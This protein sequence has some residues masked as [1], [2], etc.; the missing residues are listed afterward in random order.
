MSK[1]GGV[2][3]Y[4]SAAERC[5]PSSVRVQIPATTFPTT[6]AGAGVPGRE[7]MSSGGG[8]SRGS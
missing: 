6:V 5:Q 4:H 1:H 3:S 2:G 8:Q 7:V